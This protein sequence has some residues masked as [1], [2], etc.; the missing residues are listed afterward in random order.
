MLR[1]ADGPCVPNNTRIYGVSVATYFGSFHG[2]FSI[3]SLCW[4][5]PLVTLDLAVSVLTAVIGILRPRHLEMDN[6]AVFCR[7][8]FLVL[9]YG[10]FKTDGELL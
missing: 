6:R 10:P 8:P 1:S 3:F 4:D 5:V 9:R 2:Y 7:E